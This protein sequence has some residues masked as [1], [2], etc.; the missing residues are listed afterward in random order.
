MPRDRCQT[1]NSEKGDFFHSLSRGLSSSRI[2]KIRQ[3]NLILHNSRPRKISKP[4]CHAALPQI[5]HHK[6]WRCFITENNFYP[7]VTSNKSGA[8]T[9]LVQGNPNIIPFFNHKTIATLLSQ[10]VLP[11]A[12]LSG[13][14]LLSLC[15]EF[16]QED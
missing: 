14:M 1:H 11:S 8:V 12:Q 3:R 16:Q 9:F 13:C 6:I 15:N 2:N 5:F 7:L 10:V 4:E